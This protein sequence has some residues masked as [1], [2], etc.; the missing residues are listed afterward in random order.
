MG[1]TGLLVDIGALIAALLL[2]SSVDREQ[3]AQPDG[4][5]GRLDAMTDLALDADKLRAFRRHCWWFRIRGIQ[6][7][8]Q[9]FFAL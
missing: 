3:T 9:G 2:K 1:L 5:A 8:T 7:S 4:T 6:K